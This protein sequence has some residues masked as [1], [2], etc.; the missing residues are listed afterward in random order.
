ML[1]II[2]MVNI[3]EEALILLKMGI[4]MKDFF[5]MAIFMVSELILLLILYLKDNLLMIK[6][7]EKG[8]LNIKMEIL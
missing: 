5:K 6:N 1:V 2:K 4:A 8:L 7:M 3:M